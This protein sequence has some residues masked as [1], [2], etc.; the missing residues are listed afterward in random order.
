MH[1]KI[2]FPLLFQIAFNLMPI[3]GVI[4]GHWTL[5][6]VIY[7][8][9]METMIISF[10]SF[11]KIVSAQG[12]KPTGDVKFKAFVVTGSKWKL[13]FKYLFI[14]IATLLFYLLFIVVFVGFIASNKGDG[15]KNFDLVLLRNPVFNLTLL[16]YTLSLG[17]D[18]MWHYFGN[19]EY[20]RAHP[21]DNA[22]FIDGR[23]IVMHMVIV[24]GAV[25]FSFVKEN[26][27][28]N[29][30]LAQLYFIG[31]FV[32]VKTIADVLLYYMG[33]KPVVAS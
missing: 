30:E 3:Y 19:G 28:Y 33:R 15:S 13:G 25:G 31:V 32:L 20:L 6:S 9:W 2:A 11:I 4:V 12:D 22:S 16:L 26:Y 14:R 24:F 23:T 21:S 7:L 29:G 17:M 27:P 18:L 10:F 1:H 8:Y 5:F